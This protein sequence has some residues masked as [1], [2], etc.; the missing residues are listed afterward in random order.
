MIQD[1]HVKPLKLLPDDRGFLMEMLREDDDLFQ[2]FG[3]VYIT[4]CRRGM[5]KAWHYHHLQTDHFTC[6]SGRALLVLVDTREGSSTRGESQEFVLEAPPNDT[7]PPVLVQIPPLVLH[8]F[9]ALDC[10]EARIVNVPT[11]VYRY[12]EPDEHR[13]AWNSP[14]VPYRWPAFV[15]GGG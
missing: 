13:Y 8:G 3:Q 2:R 14:D 7:R 4:G 1:V 10:D 12:A 6:V 15:L 9:T 11:Q 5:A